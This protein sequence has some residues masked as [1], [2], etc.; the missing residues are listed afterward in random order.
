MLRRGIKL[1]NS[2]LKER[3]DKGRGGKATG[4]SVSQ[5]KCSFKSHQSK[6]SHEKPISVSFFIVFTYA[7][8]PSVKPRHKTILISISVPAPGINENRY[9]DLGLKPVG[10]NKM[11]ISSMEFMRGT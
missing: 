3:R 9:A 10:R 8:L 11:L 5:T 6:W 2:K 7:V 1:K 4:S